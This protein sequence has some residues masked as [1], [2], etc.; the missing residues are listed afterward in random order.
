MVVELT[1]TLPS[2]S[3]GSKTITLIYQSFHFA[4]TAKNAIFGSLPLRSGDNSDKLQFNAWFMP[5]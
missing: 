3:A 1:G 5:F 4:I 2:F